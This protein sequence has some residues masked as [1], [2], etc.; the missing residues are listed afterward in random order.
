MISE[1]GVLDV[2]PN[3][4]V[5]AL[6]YTITSYGADF[7]V[8]G[9]VTRMNSGDIV[10]PSFDP[11][12]SGVIEMH[13][14]QRGFVWSRPQ[15]D[16]FVES[17]LLGLPVPGIFLVREPSNVFLVLDGQQRLRTLQAFYAGDISGIPYQLEFVQEPWVGATY[18]GLDPEDRRRLDSSVVH[19]TILRQ[20]EPLGEQRAVY[21]IF[22]R[23][24]TAGTP[25]QPQEIRVALYGGPFIGLIRR[26]NNHKSWR[27]LYGNRSPRLKDHELILRYF[28]MFEHSDTYS[29]PLKGFLNEYL[30]QNRYRTDEESTLLIGL[31]RGTTD[32]INA[33]IGRAAF[34]PV[35][36]LN[37]AVAESMMVG[38]S[39][40]LA[41][42]D[43]EKPDG[44]TRAY[45]R[46]IGNSEYIF[47]TTSSTAAEESVELRLEL[48]TKAFRSLK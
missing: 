6:P 21:T 39:R 7:L 5:L 38:L 20:E 46:L 29:R 34:R 35:R 31:F 37:A 25:L 12:Y 33:V 24:N 28:A 26:L 42:G 14:F 8:D 9:L 41:E 22:E 10:V 45:E 15:M 16:R 1:G 19:A 18:A 36:S 40:R 44:V 32:L 4:E 48:A 2:D 23:L 11:E 27:A 17:L 43:I 47:A 3:E 13:A 30:S